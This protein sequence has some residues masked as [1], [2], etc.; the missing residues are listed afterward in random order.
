MPRLPDVRRNAAATLALLAPA[1][2]LVL[3]AWNPPAAL[4]F[5][6]GL[7]A[8]ALASGVAVA[9]L[10]RTPPPRG[11]DLD[12]ARALHAEA[13][14]TLERAA[15]LIGE[16]EARADAP[17]RPPRR[18][19]LGMLAVGVAF[20]VACGA[21]W[22]VAARDAQAPAIHEHARF[23]VFVDG[24][25]LDYGQPAYDLSARGVMRGHLHA[26]DGETLHVE[27]APGLAFGAFFH[28]TLMGRLEPGRV[29]LDAGHGGRALEGVP[30]RLLVAH[31]DAGAWS[32]AADPAAYEPRDGDRILLVVG[33][34]PGVL[35]AWAADAP[36]R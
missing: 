29:T 10:L 13:V 15:R 8:V 12:K 36:T 14:A 9:L 7:A 17:A 4:A 6:L 3:A 18:R 1:A 35:P 22:A 26:P 32:T 25:R 11:A 27:G 16:A 31:G 23:A 21:L 20:L 28:D 34:A 19:A 33:A 5:R 24:E 30:V 2:L